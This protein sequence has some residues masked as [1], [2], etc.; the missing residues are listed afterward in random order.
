MYYMFKYI[1]IYTYIYIYIYNFNQ[2]KDV[3]SRLLPEWF[4]GNSCTYTHDPRL[5]I[6]DTNEP[7][8]A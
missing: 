7:K 5:Y 2:E 1:Y 6:V 3:P 8:I 4:Y